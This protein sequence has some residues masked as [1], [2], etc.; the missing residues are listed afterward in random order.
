MGW[1]SSADGWHK[2]DGGKSFLAQMAALPAHYERDIR[3][4]LKGSSI[5]ADRYTL[6]S[7]SRLTVNI[8]DLGFALTAQQAMDL[9]VAANWDTLTP[10]DLT[11]AANRAGKDIYLYV[12]RQPGGIPKFVLS[13][14]STVPT[15]YTSSN[16]RKIGGFHCLC[17][18]TSITTSGVTLA[19]GADHPLKDFETGDVLPNSIWDL[20]WKPRNRN[21]E[22][23]FYS[24]LA[25][26]AWVDIYLASG[27][28]A[29]TSSAYGAT[30]SDTRN[31]MDFVDDGAAVNKRLTKD[32]EFQGYAA[33][34]NEQT[35]IAGSADPVTTGGHVD[36]AG[37]RMISYEG[38]EDCCGAM[39]Q[40][41][42]ENGYQLGTDGSVT[43]ASKTATITHVAV[44]EGN[45]LYI[46]FF[47][48]GTPYL[49][50][51][52]STAGANKTVAFGTNNIVQITN[53]INA[54]T[55]LPL[56]FDEDATQ[57]G[58]MLCNNTVLGQDCYVAT[59]NPAFLLQI[60]Y[61]SNAAA[62]GVAVKY[63]DVTHNRLEFTSP[64]STNG[65]L[66]LASTTPAFSWYALPGSKGQLYRQG[67]LGDTKLLAGA[68]WTIATYCGSRARFA[69]YARWYTST[70]IGGRFAAE[71]V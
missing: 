31:H 65:T 63:D 34:S 25:G 14:N 22:G 71:P 50:A 6:L 19:L 61:A 11:V 64:T 60:K 41:L 43:A 35:N 36:T 23:M 9:S 55:G 32:R 33:G 5:A 4:A 16:S 20:K 10:V 51:N 57:P 48:D 8:S 66:D 45:Q 30:I 17:K 62:L 12:C 46:K 38:A 59:S 21:P 29:N 40:W 54:A 37:R 18:G 28:A 3:W 49:C 52:L 24:F 7:P 47:S 2:D 68:S 1:K 69:A 26:G 42:D 15:G 58:R 56:Y 39:Y 44:P 53:D 70:T 27:T 67:S 13:A